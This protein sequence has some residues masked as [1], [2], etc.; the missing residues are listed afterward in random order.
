MQ[1]KREETRG[2]R[3]HVL[4]WLES[5]RFLEELNGCLRGTGAVVRPDDRWMP[6]GW[7]APEEARLERFGPEHLPEAGDWGALLRWW[8]KYPTRANTPNWDLASTCRVGSRRGLLLVEAK[9]HSFEMSM[10]GKTLSQKATDRS[11]ANDTRI[12]EAIQQASAALAGAVPGV[13][14]SASRE[15]QLANRVAHA[16]WLAT[17][18][19]PTVL[20]YLAFLNDTRMRDLGEPLKDEED[21]R[22]WFG[23]HSRGI[24]P[25]D[26]A[27]RWIDCGS[28]GMYLALR[29]RDMPIGYGR[30]G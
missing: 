28:A 8:L 3:R 14:L 15:Y 29:V 1:L 27:E 26:F 30:V 18:G 19:I 4:D 13:A 21:W 25:S 7:N 17:Q 10:S 5:P 16:W 12:R 11:R 6:A 24:L 9:A 22:G 23:V 2:S 20:I